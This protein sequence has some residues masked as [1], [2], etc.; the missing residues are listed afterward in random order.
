MNAWKEL[1]K[2]ERLGSFVKVDDE[3]I[4]RTAHIGSSVDVLVYKDGNCSTEVSHRFREVLY[5]R[6]ER[7]GK[8]GIILWKD[9]EAF[10]SGWLKWVYYLPFHRCFIG[11]SKSFNIVYIFSDDSDDVLFEEECECI[12]ALGSFLFFSHDGKL[13]GLYDSKNKRKIEPFFE[14]YDQRSKLMHSWTDEY[15]PVKI[16]EHYYLVDPYGN[17]FCKHSEPIYKY[18]NIFAT[19]PN[20]RTTCFGLNS[21]KEICMFP[22]TFYTS[23]EGS[24]LVVQRREGDL[25]RH[26]DAYGKLREDA[27]Y[28]QTGYY[29]ELIHISVNLTTYSRQPMKLNGYKFTGERLFDCFWKISYKE[30]FCP[31]RYGVFNEE[32]NEVITE[33]M[34]NEVMVSGRGIDCVNGSSVYFLD[35]CGKLTLAGEKASYR[36]V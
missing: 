23:Y 16:K 28:Y 9:G 22:N 17:C 7:D 6:V 24:S 31:E 18:T 10:F 25:W 1:T 11:H 27:D 12:I 36:V 5:R 3:E 29:G 4:V 30:D 35:H 21:K 34:F 26:I 14:L 15:Y 13:F 33:P 19:E 8:Q 32:T 2:A 20:S